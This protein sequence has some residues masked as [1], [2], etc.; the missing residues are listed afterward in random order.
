MAR[1]SLRLGRGGMSRLGVVPHGTRGSPASNQN[2]CHL[3][4]LHI[5]EQREVMS[6]AA[7]GCP[8]NTHQALQISPEFMRIN[9]GTAFSARTHL[10]N[11]V[12]WK[13]LWLSKLSA[14]S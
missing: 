9:V 12:S 14:V 1:S 11:D 3:N 8:S 7:G 2:V 4:T 10:K 6:A 13:V 5:R